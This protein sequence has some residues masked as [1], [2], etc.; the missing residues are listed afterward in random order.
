MPEENVLTDI[1]QTLKAAI[2]GRLSLGGQAVPVR[3][4]TPDPDYV[5]LELP[6]VTLQLADVRRD[7]P[8]IVNERRVEKDVGAMTAGIRPRTE[9]FNLHYTVGIHAKGTR[10][11]RLLIE[12]LL[13][14]IDE[15]PKMT[16]DVFG[17]EI[18]VSR[19]LSF[20]ERSNGRDFFHAFTVIVKTR[21]E[22]GQTKTV[23][24]V[25]E[26]AFSAKEA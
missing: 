21:L 7:P 20:S 9:P 5:E 12:Q 24:L 25:A 15:R 17:R 4:V 13:L 18:Y 1:E 14:L 10:D 11:G 3:I 6:C 22:P 2:E 23:P 26:A 8:R 19:E 16:T